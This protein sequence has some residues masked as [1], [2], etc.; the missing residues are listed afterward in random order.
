MAKRFPAFVESDFEEYVDICS[1]RMDAYGNRMLIAGEAI[2]KIEQEAV[3]KAEQ[4]DGANASSK[5]ETAAE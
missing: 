2:S 3:L 4:T 5:D 1:A